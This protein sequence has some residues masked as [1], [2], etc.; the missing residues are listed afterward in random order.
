LDAAHLGNAR[1]RTGIDPNGDDTQ[2]SRMLL[3]EAKNLGAEAGHIDA[4]R[5][6]TTI[7]LAAKTNS[8]D[9]GVATLN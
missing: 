3:D 2:R 6:A 9:T 1:P 4:K 8:S 5:T 7:S